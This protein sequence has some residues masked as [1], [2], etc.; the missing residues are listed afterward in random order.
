MSTGTDRENLEAQFDLLKQLDREFPDGELIP[1]AV[2]GKKPAR[3]FGLKTPASSVRQVT[4]QVRLG[5]KFAIRPSTFGVLGLD[6]D[7]GGEAAAKAVSARLTEMGVD[8]VILRSGQPGRFHVLALAGDFKASNAKWQYGEIRHFNGYLTAHDPV[9]EIKWLLLTKGGNNRL[10]EAQYKQ[11]RREFPKKKTEAVKPAARAGLEL[12]PAEPGLKRDFDELAGMG[13]GNRHD[14]VYKVTCD[15]ARNGDVELIREL[16]H[17]AVSIGEPIGEVTRTQRDALR[18]VIEAQAKEKRKGEVS[19]APTT[20][21]EALQRPEYQEAGKKLHEFLPAPGGIALLSGSPE[22]GKTTFAYALAGLMTREGKKVLIVNSEM[23]PYEIAH[24]SSKVE[25]NPELVFPYNLVEK[26]PDTEQPNGK[27]L[28]KPAVQ[29]DAELRSLIKQIKP[30]VII[31][32]LITTFWDFTFDVFN[33][34]QRVM[35]FSTLSPNSLARAFTYMWSLIGKA[36]VLG[37]VHT[38]K[39]KETAG[40]IPGHQQFL[41]TANMG[42]VMF[43]HGR[44]RGMPAS[45][46]DDLQKEDADTRGLTICKDRTGGGRIRWFFTHLIGGEIDWQERGATRESVTTGK[47]TTAK[48]MGSRSKGRPKTVD[49]RAEIERVLRG[50]EDGDCKSKSAVYRRVGGSKTNFAKVFEQLEA[51]GKISMET[52][53]VAWVDSQQGGYSPKLDE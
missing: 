39:N 51:E 31:F 15:A 21:A 5:G 27:P 43:S 28:I 13:V 44:I 1:I 2:E 20:L 16:A 26:P 50:A 29:I 14:M 17:R 49:T 4:A 36:A 47:D 12:K 3:G 7:E 38:P 33:D 24:T 32:D 52:G 22:S 42:M 48:S 53:G 8:H 30:E 46:F 34:R 45:V 9:K 19:V 18:D 25:H 40:T 41:G 35:E 37:L 6:V 23:Q 11:L 10:S